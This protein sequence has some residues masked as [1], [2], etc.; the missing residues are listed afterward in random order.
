MDDVVKSTP[1]VPSGGLG[2]GGKEK[3]VVG[4][5]AGELPLTPVGQEAELP[6]EVASAGVSAQPTSIS[7]PPNVS[8][9]GVTPL[10]QN[11][12]ATPSGGTVTLPLSDDQI[13]Q[14]MRQNITNSWRWLAQWC[15]R[16]LM[17]IHA[18][19]RGS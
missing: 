3:E 11:V 12:S 1:S 2:I 19:L 13:A 6:K 14:G 8:Q 10:G 15:K 4:A 5:I 16:R 17:Q 18:R 7:I 9:M